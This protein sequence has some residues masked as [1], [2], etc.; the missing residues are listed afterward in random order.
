MKV[1]KAQASENRNAITKAA[2]EEVRRLGFDGVSVAHVAS[3][4]GLTHGALYSHY[5]SKDGLIE[6]A[7]RRAFEDTLREFSGLPFSEFV[8]R[9]L[10]SAHRDHP[11]AGCPNA[12]LMSE[13]WRQPETTR[14]A[15][16]DGLQQYVDLVAQ[17]LNSTTAA[18]VRAQAVTMLAAMV[19]GMALSRAVRDV[20]TAFSDEILSDIGAQLK[21]FVESQKTPA[22]NASE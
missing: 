7:T 14:V 12:A 3:T 8:E 21:S 11:E 16:R 2:A 13:V 22:A 20:D 1:S 4:A 10:S 15:F 19:G 9:Y 17:S 6:A 18:P 5:D